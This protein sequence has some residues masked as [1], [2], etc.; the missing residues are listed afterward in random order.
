MRSGAKVCKS[1]CT[2]GCAASAH[3]SGVPTLAS[4][5]NLRRQPLNVGLYLL[6]PI[7][8]SA[9]KNSAK[10][11]QTFSHFC[12]FIFKM[13]HNFSIVV[14]NSP[15]PILMFSFRDFCNFTENI[16]I[17]YLPSRFSNFE[18]EDEQIS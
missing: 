5:A 10:F 1:G 7:H 4:E 3:G 9:F 16:K 2:A 12:S 17:S 18:N 14:Q 6:N 13:L 11:R 8:R 15:G